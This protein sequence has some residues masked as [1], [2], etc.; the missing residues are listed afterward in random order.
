MKKILFLF[1]ST[2][3]VFCFISCKKTPIGSEKFFKYPLSKYFS[4]IEHNAPNAIFW[5]DKD[6]KMQWQGA[7]FEP[8]YSSFGLED[9]KEIRPETSNFDFGIKEFKFINEQSVALIY[10]D[11]TKLNDT[12]PY[13]TIFPVT[14]VMNGFSVDPYVGSLSTD[15]IGYLWFDIIYYKYRKGTSTGI[16]ESEVKQRL[17]SRKSNQDEMEFVSDSLKL[18]KGDT[19]VYVFDRI[20]FK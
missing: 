11:S 14:L 4:K 10:K 7:F 16:Y 6:K 2:L 9:Y 1:I 17:V 8:F 5:S 20:Y 3:L 19:L 15:G 13:H 18:I 12:L